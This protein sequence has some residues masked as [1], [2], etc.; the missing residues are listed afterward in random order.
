MLEDIAAASSSIHINQFGF[1]PGVV[2]ERF[3][4]ALIAKARRASRCGSSSTGRARIPTRSRERSTSASRGAGVEVCVVRA[5]K[6]RAPAR[7]AGRRRRAAVEPRA[8]RAHRPSQGRRRRR[9]DRL[10]RRRRDRGPLRG[11]PLPRPVP[12]RRR[13]RSWRSCSSSSSRASAGSAGT[14]ARGRARRALPRSTRRRRCRAG[15]S[16]CTTRPGRYRPITDAIAE[17]LDGATRDA[18]R[19]QPVRH[20]P[21][22]DPAD[23]AGGPARRARPPVRPR[24]TR[25]TGRARPRSSSTTRRSSTRACA[26]SSTRRCCTRR[27][28][29]AT[30]RR[31]SQERATSRP[32]ASSGSSRSTFAC[33]RAQLAAQFDERFSAPAEGLSTAGRRSSA[34][35][36]RLRGE[37]SRRSRRCSEAGLAV[38]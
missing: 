26:S 25:T 28:S 8:A 32:G 5:T 16:S 24:R 29:C 15:A 18:R 36:E 3:A 37:R 23:R 1:R 34:H 33:G 17:L 10:G 19:R 22:D 2:G 21:R 38:V 6:P 11:R 12:A 13:A 35:V 20:R 30:A 27:R 4:E 31:C 9:P 14:V 7:P